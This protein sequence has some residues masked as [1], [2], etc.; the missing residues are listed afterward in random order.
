[1][2][3]NPLVEGKIQ[4]RQS[5]IFLVDAMLLVSGSIQ[6]PCIKYTSMLWQ[7]K[8]ITMKREK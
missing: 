8:P 5:K 7:K 6:N 4:N 1:M 3:A 2:A